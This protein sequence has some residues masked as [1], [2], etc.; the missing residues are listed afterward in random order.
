MKLAVNWSELK[1]G[2]ELA[3]KM[4]GLLNLNKTIYFNKT[5]SKY[6]KFDLKFSFALKEISY[7]R[8]L[9]CVRYKPLMALTE[10][11]VAVNISNLMLRR[12][13]EKGQLFIGKKNQLRTKKRIE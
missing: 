11:G 9:T 12:K 7:L 13:F 10:K 8:F 2:I 4:R 5:G 3:K 6:R 1:L